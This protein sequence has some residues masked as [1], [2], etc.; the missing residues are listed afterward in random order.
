MM[1]QL[2]FVVL[3]ALHS[4]A[5]A[6]PEILHNVIGDDLAGTFAVLPLRESADGKLIACGLEFSAL[7]HDRST[8]KGAPVKIVGSYYLRNYSVAGLGYSLKLGIYDGLTWTNPSPP[9]QAFVRSVRGPSSPTASRL[10]A[11]TPGFALFFGP[12]Y[13]SI[14]Q[15]LKGIMDEGKLVVG[16]NRAPDQQ[17]VVLTLDLYVESTQMVK[18]RVVRRRSPRMVEDFSV[19]VNELLS[20][21]TK[22]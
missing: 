6:Q 18:D 1:S 13:A 16:F 4:T 12:A 15:V 14:N 8:K 7:T 2:G 17:D 10:L 20:L 22:R 11:E 9:H 21:Q 3:S 19:C 5:F